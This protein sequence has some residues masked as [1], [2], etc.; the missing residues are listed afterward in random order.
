M[1][2]V[3][4]SPP[5]VAIHVYPCGPMAMPSV[6]SCGNP[7][8]REL[9]TSHLGLCAWQGRMASRSAPKT[10]AAYIT[11]RAWGLLWRTLMAFPPR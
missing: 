3:T 9:K 8:L 5:D 2:S 10:K 11:E 6:M 4:A 7:E 1:P